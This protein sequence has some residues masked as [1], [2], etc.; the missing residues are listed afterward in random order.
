MRW[1]PLGEHRGAPNSVALS[2]GGV[3]P[4][5]ARMTVNDTSTIENLNLS[6]TIAM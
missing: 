1:S 6:S 4:R 2:F 3:G 5:R